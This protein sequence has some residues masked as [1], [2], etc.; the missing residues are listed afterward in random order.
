MDGAGLDISSS[1]AQFYYKYDNSGGNGN[2][3]PLSV[4]GDLLVD[5]NSFNHLKSDVTNLVNYLDASFLNVLLFNEF[6]GI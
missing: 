5:G 3:I 2:H 6:L 1:V 4:S